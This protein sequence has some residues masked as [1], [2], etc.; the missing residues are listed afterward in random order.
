MSLLGQQAAQYGSLLP[1]LGD[2]KTV[3]VVEGKLH[4]KKGGFVHAIRHLHNIPVH[5]YVCMYVCVCVC[6]YG[7]G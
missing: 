7:Y 5:M 6:L 4:A 1:K 2:E 3:A